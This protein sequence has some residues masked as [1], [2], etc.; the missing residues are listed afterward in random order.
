MLHSISGG[1]FGSLKELEVDIKEVRWFQDQYAKALAAE[2][3]LSERQI[4]N[5][6]RKKT[7]TYGT[8]INLIKSKHPKLTLIDWEDLLSGPIIS[9]CNS[10][11]QKWNENAGHGARGVQSGHFR[12]FW[13]SL[14]VQS[15]HFG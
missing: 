1:H 5:I 7:D 15:G 6:F 10:F 9:Q 14:G 3:S 4:K 11:F 8:Y 13:T 2:T 12:Q